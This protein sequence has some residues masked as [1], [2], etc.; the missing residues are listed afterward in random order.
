MGGEIRRHFRPLRIQFLPSLSL[1]DKN[2]AKFHSSAENSAWQFPTEPRCPRFCAAGFSVRGERDL[3][4]RAGNS[5]LPLPL[6]RQG[7][8]PPASAQRQRIRPRIPREFVSPESTLFFSL[9]PRSK[10]SSRGVVPSF[11]YINLKLRSINSLVIDA[12]LR[13]HSILSRWILN[14]AMK[15]GGVKD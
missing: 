11:F 10:G 5:S 7:I 9:P 2:R 1:G 6:F 8:L 14:M 4:Q 15:E 12:L 13:P 3:I